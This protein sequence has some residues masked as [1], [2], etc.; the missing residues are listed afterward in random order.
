MMTRD[1]NPSEI[2]E[3]ALDDDL[4]EQAQEW[5]L[6]NS[7]GAVDTYGIIRQGRQEPHRMSD[8]AWGNEYD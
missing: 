8:D 1:H 3:M 5:E 6:L 7:L 2:F 4:I